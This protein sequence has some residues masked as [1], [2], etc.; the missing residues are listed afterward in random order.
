MIDHLDLPPEQ[1]LPEPVR[2]AA[3]DRLRA[4]MRADPGRASRN[5]LPLAVAAGVVMLAAVVVGMTAL[6]GVGAHVSA[7]SQ[8]LRTDRELPPE[9]TD[10]AYHVQHGSAPAAE[11]GRCLARANRDGRPGPEQWQ[12][13]L[14]ATNYD[15]TVIAYRTS[16]GPVFCEVTPT[17]VALSQPGSPVKS[18]ARPTFITSFGTVAGTIDPGYRAAWVDQRM[19][20]Q[21]YA[22]DDDM[23]QSAVVADGIFLL[24]DAIPVP[25][26]GL[27]LGVAP[28]PAAA[29]MRTF[30]LTQSQL[31]AVVQPTIDNAAALPPAD[32]QTAAGQRLTA[33]FHGP[34][35]V[36]V[37]AP[38]A[39]IPG[40]YLK[41]DQ[42]E[43]VQVASLGA[44]NNLLAVCTQ[45]TGRPIDLFVFDQ[46]GY[47]FFNTIDPNQVITAT[48]TPYDFHPLASGGMGADEAAIVGQVLSPR[49][50]AVRMTWPGGPDLRAVVTAGTYALP[51]YNVNDPSLRGAK[52]T[53]T[54]YDAHGKA[55]RSFQVHG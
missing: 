3:R 30:T 26:N 24:P 53:I 32:Q 55:I 11:A 7:G 46:T 36:P 38:Q 17:T 41:L 33:C 16:A 4:G 49:V 23:Y 40:A 44:N 5:M 2:A 25:T 15:D 12:V 31:P 37:V 18:T 28:T 14:T 34:N 39:W 13:L 8:Y 19:V 48:E 27:E 50:A 6:S 35:S 22:I 45:R 52:P 47:Y 20:G 21:P 10:A 51:G 43:D 54:V 42:H 9:D 29:D 1:D